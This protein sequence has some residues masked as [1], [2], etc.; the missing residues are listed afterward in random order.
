MYYHNGRSYNVGETIATINSVFGTI[1]V[2]FEED[3]NFDMT[4][5]ESYV[6][7]FAVERKNVGK[8]QSVESALVDLYSKIANFEAMKDAGT[9]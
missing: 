3:D 9:L 7:A 1:E 2:K 5:K 4:A 8:G 6:S